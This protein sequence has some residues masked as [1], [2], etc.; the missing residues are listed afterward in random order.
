MSYNNFIFE[1]GL[2]SLKFGFT[3]KG[4]K[5]A[6]VRVG[7]TPRKRLE[8]GNY[9]DVGESQFYGM[10]FYGEKAEA[11]ERIFEGKIGAQVLVS[12]TLTLQPYKNQQGVM[13]PSY[14]VEN[15]KLYLQVAGRQ[16]V[17]LTLPP[18]NSN[19]Q[20][21]QQ[22]ANQQYQQAPAPQGGYQQTGQQQGGW[23]AQPQ[24]QTD[25]W[26]AGVGSDDAPF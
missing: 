16:E 20:Y 13:V 19:G 11:I 18:K 9:G 14:V 3:K 17:S 15:P 10:T 12:G 7:T 1:G 21:Q 5:F 22:D 8:D 2:S 4:I 23:Q 6:N 26:D 25:Q 24:Y